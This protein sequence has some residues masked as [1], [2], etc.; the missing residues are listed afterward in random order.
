MCLITCLLVGEPI[1]I[2]TGC[3]QNICLEEQ[4]QEI[5]QLNTADTTSASQKRKFTSSIL[6]N[7]TNGFS[8]FDS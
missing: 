4:E 6:H 1:D 5:F 2:R 3:F 8:I 7:K